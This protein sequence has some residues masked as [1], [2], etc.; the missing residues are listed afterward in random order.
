MFLVF[1]VFLKYNLCH[2]VKECVLVFIAI[3]QGFIYAFNQ[4]ANTIN[5]KLRL[6]NKQSNVLKQTTIVNQQI[7]EI[8]NI[9]YNERRPGLLSIYKEKIY[10]FTSVGGFENKLSQC[11]ISEATTFSFR[12]VFSLDTK[13]SCACRSDQP[14]K[15]AKN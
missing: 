8:K 13:I 4:T 7:T 3:Y 12:Q 9:V 10:I 15:T 1:Y 5:T 2:N 14:I 6:T 11:K